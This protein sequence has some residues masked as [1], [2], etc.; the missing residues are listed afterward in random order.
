MNT[1]AL[2]A[3]E[4]RNKVTEMAEYFTY[5]T[6]EKAG[7]SSKIETNLRE[8]PGRETQ[9]LIILLFICNYSLVGHYCWGNINKNKI[10]ENLSTKVKE[11]KRFSLLNYHYTRM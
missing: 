7:I 10:L 8:G 4:Y 1:T 6:P 3:E 5:T 9:T 11:K 2:P